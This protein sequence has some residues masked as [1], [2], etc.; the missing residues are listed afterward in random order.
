[1][2]HL[3]SL[4]PDGVFVPWEGGVRFKALPTSTH[5]EV[6]RLLRVVLAYLA[7]RGGY[8]PFWST[9]S[10]PCGLRKWPQPRDPPQSAWC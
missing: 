10:C 9:W 1:M 5:V 4:V 8:A 6:E 3:H 2:L 7:A